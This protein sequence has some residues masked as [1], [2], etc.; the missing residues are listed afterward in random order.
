[1]RCKVRRVRTVGHVSCRGTGYAVRGMNS[2][3]FRGRR[4]VVTTRGRKILEYNVSFFATLLGFLVD[5]YA[6]LLRHQ[7]ACLNGRK[8]HHV[9][10]HDRNPTA[11]DSYM[12]EIQTCMHIWEGCVTTFAYV[13]GISIKHT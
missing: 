8:F 12:V 4:D 11:I 13:I 3:N 9:C 10:I 5:G 6:L 2:K 1:M 7:H